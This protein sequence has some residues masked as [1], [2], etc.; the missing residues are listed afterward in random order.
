M[1]WIRRHRP[2]PGT[3]FGFAALVVAL[4]GVAFAAIP[5]SNGTINGCF[6]KPNGNLR[7]VESAADCRANESSISWGQNSGGRLVFFGPVSVPGAQSPD[8]T[9]RT[10]FTLGPFSVRGACQLNNTTAFPGRPIPQ[11]F[12]TGTGFVGDHGVATAR[13]NSD[14][15]QPGSSFDDLFQLLPDGRT[16]SGKI[17]AGV[18]LNGQTGDCVFAGHLVLGNAGGS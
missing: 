9:T 13:T 10:V 8:T 3:A 6:Q 14:H 7:V 15:G 4:G 18:N 5:D 2:S 1:N 11:D 17:F 12:S 16:L